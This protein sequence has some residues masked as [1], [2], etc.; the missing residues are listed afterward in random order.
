MTKETKQL[1]LFSSV[2]ITLITL[3]IV[4]VVIKSKRK[5]AEAIKIE[6]EKIKEAVAK[7]TAA[8]NVVKPIFNRNGELINDF[9]EIKGKKLI[10]KSDSNIRSTPSINNPTWYAETHTNLLGKA[11][12]GNSIGVIVGESQGK[13]TPPM[14]WLKVKLDTPI[15]VS[16]SLG[17]GLQMISQFFSDAKPGTYEYGYV[18]ADVSTFNQYKK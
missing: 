13:E 18:R 9:S 1:V 6:D 8:T 7:E 3:T 15:K 5:E 2:A 14:R 11:V 4:F 16:A 12:K 10:A 17:T